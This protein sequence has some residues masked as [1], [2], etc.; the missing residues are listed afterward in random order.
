L[1]RFLEAG[2][3]TFKAMRGADEFLTTVGSRERALMAALFEPAE[4][5]PTLVQ[6][7]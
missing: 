3:D 7:P 6:L 4:P 5:H 2:F 1:Q